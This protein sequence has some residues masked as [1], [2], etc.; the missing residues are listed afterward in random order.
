MLTFR[1]IFNPHLVESVAFDHHHERA[2]E[3][4]GNWCQFI[5]RASSRMNGNGVNSFFDSEK[6]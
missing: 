1:Q 3:I 5:F 4:E 6:K 2:G